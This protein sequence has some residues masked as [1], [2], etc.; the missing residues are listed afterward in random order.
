MAFVNADPPTDPLINYCPAALIQL[1]ASTSQQV[2]STPHFR[3]WAAKEG[4]YCVGVFD[5]K[6][7]TDFC[8]FTDRPEY[9]GIMGFNR[10]N[11]R[12][13]VNSEA[14]STPSNTGIAVLDPPFSIMSTGTQTSGAIFNGLH[15][16]AVLRV[17]AIQVVESIP[18]QFSPDI[19]LALQSSAPFDPAALEAYRLLVKKLPAGCTWA[20]NP[21]GEWFDKVMHFLA[22]VAPTIGR[23]FGTTVAGAPGSAMGENIG[24]TAS[25]VFTYA[26]EF[27]ASLR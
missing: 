27:N 3:S 6:C 2:S 25:S 22:G 20:E 8:Y 13:V 12:G 10:Q 15:K 19:H 26:R 11:M 17:K 16:N 9:A 18:D 7:L 5:P 14:A 1:P 23:V 21:F 24:N 4:C